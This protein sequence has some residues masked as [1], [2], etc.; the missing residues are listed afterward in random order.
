[1]NLKEKGVVECA[2]Q[3]LQGEKFIKETAA[4]S[5]M[6]AP[7][8]QVRPLLEQIKSK[9]T[10]TRTTTTTNLAQPPPH[11]PPKK[12]PGYCFLNNTL[13]V[14]SLPLHSSKPAFVRDV[15]A[16]FVGTKLKKKK[17]K[18][19]KKATSDVLHCSDPA[20]QRTGSEQPEPS[21]ICKFSIKDAERGGQRQPEY[22]TKIS[23]PPLMMSALGVGAWLGLKASAGREEEEE[24][25]EGEEEGETTGPSNLF[26]TKRSCD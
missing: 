9:H 7:N 26:P 1:M 8:K 17:K 20:E 15:E 12:A 14:S 4:T 23:S 16:S 24:G 25:E 21:L 10:T 11:T 19:T 6:K 3:S 2:R 13:S 22:V 18:Q 5:Q